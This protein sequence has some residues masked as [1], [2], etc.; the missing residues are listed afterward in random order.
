[1]LEASGDEM[2]RNAVQLIA[3]KGW[4]YA[5][6][7]FESELVPGNDYNTQMWAMYLLCRMRHEHPSEMAA[8]QS[9]V[10]NSEPAHKTKQTTEA[11]KNES[12]LPKS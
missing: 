1:M 3:D 11:A 5:V 7:E 12:K 9:E 10:K 6:N 8:A 4:A 2:Y